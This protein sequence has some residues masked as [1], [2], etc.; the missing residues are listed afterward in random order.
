MQSVLIMSPPRV[1]LSECLGSQR[2]THSKNKIVHQTGQN[3]PVFS[4]WVPTRFL[5]GDK[6]TMECAD[7]SWP[8]HLPIFSIHY[9]YL[10]LKLGFCLSVILSVVALTKIHVRRELSLRLIINIK[11]LSWSTVDG[12]PVSCTAEYYTKEQM[13]GKRLIVV[14]NL[15]PKNLVK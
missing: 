6:S 11:T 14:C 13:M 9:Q 5:P 10:K 2:S 3:D 8:C 1:L 4:T 7:A 12:A 15:K